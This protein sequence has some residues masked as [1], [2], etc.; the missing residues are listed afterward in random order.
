MPLEN[1]ESFKMQANQGSNECFHMWNGIMIPVGHRNFK[2]GLF[3]LDCVFVSERL[4]SG[5]CV[6]RCG[7]HL[8]SDPWPIEGFFVCSKRCC[9]VRFNHNEFSQRGQ[10][11]KTEEAKFSLEEGQGS[12]LDE[13][14]SQE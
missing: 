13:R 9:G 2:G 11:P 10:A 5:V 7:Y 4:R 8:N 1:A 3:Q 12:L 14:G 6:V